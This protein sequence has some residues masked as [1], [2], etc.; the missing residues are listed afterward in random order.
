[1]QFYLES[2]LHSFQIEL[3]RFKSIQLVGAFFKKK[4]LW[5]EI[6]NDINKI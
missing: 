2:H 4:S 1:M 3:L 6:I 5:V